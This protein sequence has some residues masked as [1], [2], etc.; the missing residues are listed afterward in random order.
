MLRRFVLV[1]ALVSASLLLVSTAFAQ[2]PFKSGKGYSILPPTGWE[3]V[4]GELAAPELEK[5]PPN[6]RDHYNPK[7]TDVLFMDSAAAKDSD[8]KDNLNVLVLDEPVP[9]N[10]ELLTELKDVLT[11]QYKSLFDSFQL[12]AFENTW[13]GR[14]VAACQAADAVV[15]D[16]IRIPVD[17]VNAVV[18]GA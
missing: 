11:E 9:I 8:F 1:L 15:I 7:E 2:D 3:V 17:V 13:A 10:P 18:S 6:V 5:L 14:F 16:Q 12:V 4:S